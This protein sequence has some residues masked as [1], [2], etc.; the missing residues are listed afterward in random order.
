MISRVRVGPVA[1]MSRTPLNPFPKPSR[2]FELGESAYRVT[3]QT[4]IVAAPS[5][6]KF[7]HNLNNTLRSGPVLNCTVTSM[8]AP[9][10][11]LTVSGQFRQ[12][13]NFGSL[14]IGGAG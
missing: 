5:D 3:H 12:I 13:C 2:P 1:Q 11:R 10:Y 6:G 9:T 7:E 14:A 8:H 4:S